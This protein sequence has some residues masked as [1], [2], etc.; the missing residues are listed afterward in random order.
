MFPS[1]TLLSAIQAADEVCTLR[2]RFAALQATQAGAQQ[3]KAELEQLVVDKR[4]LQDKVKALHSSA[5]I[6]LSLYVLY[7]SQVC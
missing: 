2:A 6:I 7:C 5:P 4:S 1:R 3:L